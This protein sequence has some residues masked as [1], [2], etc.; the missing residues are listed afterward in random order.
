MLGNESRIRFPTFQK[1]PL[2]ETIN[3]FIDGIPLER[4]EKEMLLSTDT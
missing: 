3:L 1:V 2:E 4:A